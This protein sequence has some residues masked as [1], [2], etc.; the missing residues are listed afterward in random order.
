[1]RQGP[2]TVWGHISQLPDGVRIAQTDDRPSEFG[3]TDT[4]DFKKGKPRGQGPYIAG[5]WSF[6]DNTDGGAIDQIP[7]C[8]GSS[9]EIKIDVQFKKGMDD[10]RVFWGSDSTQRLSTALPLYVRCKSAPK[11]ANGITVNE[12]CAG[13]VA[14]MC[15]YA[16]D[17]SNPPFL[18][19]TFDWSDGTTD[20]VAR[21]PAELVCADH[22]WTAPG[23]YKVQVSVSAGSGPA[24]SKELGTIKA[25]DCRPPGL[26]FPQ[27]AAPLEVRGEQADI[28]FDAA[29]PASYAQRQYLGCFQF[30]GEKA[31]GP[32]QSAAQCSLQCQGKTFFAVSGMGDC[33]CGATFTRSAEG[34]DC[35][36]DGRR[37]GGDFKGGSNK[38]VY[39]RVGV[40]FDQ[41]RGDGG[42]RKDSPTVLDQ[43]PTKYDTLEEVRAKCLQMGCSSF[44]WNDKD[45]TVVTQK[46]VNYKQPPG[47]TCKTM[48]PFCVENP[49][50]SFPVEDTQTI[51]PR[52]NRYGNLLRQPVPNWF[53][54]QV[55]RSGLLSVTLQGR[56][57]VDFAVWGPFDSKETAL[58][59][60]GKLPWQNPNRPVQS[61]YSEEETEVIRFQAVSDSTYV[62]LVTNYAKVNQ[63]I[64]LTVNS[65]NTAMTDCRVFGQNTVKATNVA[66]FCGDDDWGSVDEDSKSGWQVGRPLPGAGRAWM[67]LTGDYKMSLASQDQA[68]GKLSPHTDGGGSF[69]FPELP[70]GRRI[71]GDYAMSPPAEVTVL[72]WVKRMARAGREWVL[73][74]GSGGSERAVILADG[75]YGGD[76]VAAPSGTAPYRSTVPSD[77]NTWM[78]IAVVY[79]GAEVTVLRDGGSMCGGWQDGPMQA[80]GVTEC[81]PTLTTGGLRQVVH[82]SANV[83]IGQLTVLPLA[84]TP[85]EVEDVYEKQKERYGHVN[86]MGSETCR[87]W[88]DLSKGESVGIKKLG[89]LPFPSLSS[90]YLDFSKKGTYLLYSRGGYSVYGRMYKC[91]VAAESSCMYNIVITTANNWRVEV[92][93]DEPAGSERGTLHIYNASCS[94]ADG[95]LHRAVARVS[96]KLL[97][98]PEA[99]HGVSDPLLNSDGTSSLAAGVRNCPQGAWHSIEGALILPVPL[100][101]NA[102]PGAYVYVCRDQNGTAIAR[103]EIVRAGFTRKEQ[104]RCEGQGGM[105]GGWRAAAACGGG[106]G[107]MKLCQADGKC[108]AVV[109]NPTGQCALYSKCTAKAA[110]AG[111]G[112]GWELWEKPE[113]SQGVRQVVSPSFDFVRLNRFTQDSARR[114]HFILDLPTRTRLRITQDRAWGAPFLSAAVTHFGEFGGVEGLCTHE[115]NDVPTECSTCNFG[116]PP[117]PVPQSQPCDD[118]RRLWSEGCCRRYQHCTTQERNQC[119]AEHC[120]LGD[121]SEGCLDSV[122]YA[123]SVS[124]CMPVPPKRNSPPYGNDV[125]CKVWGPSYVTPFAFFQKQPAQAPGTNETHTIYEISGGSDAGNNLAVHGSFYECGAGRY[126]MKQ[127]IITTPS[128]TNIEVRAGV[129]QEVSKFHVYNQDEAC[130]KAEGCVMSGQN[131]AVPSQYENLRLTEYGEPGKGRTEFTFEHS[132]GVVVTLAQEALSVG[133]YITH[134]G[135]LTKVTGLCT[136]DQINN[137][138]CKKNACPFDDS[139]DDPPAPAFGGTCDASLGTKCCTRYS[140]CAAGAQ[141]G[142]AEAH[143]GLASGKCIDWP[144]AALAAHSE[145]TATPA[146]P[147]PADATSTCLA[148]GAAHYIPFPRLGLPKFELSAAVDATL[149]SSGPY[150]VHIRQEQAATG[151]VVITRVLLRLPDSSDAGIGDRLVE[152]RADEPEGEER[153]KLRTLAPGASGANQATVLDTGDPDTN[154][155]ADLG[156]GATVLSYASRAVNARTRIQLRGGAELSVAWARTWRGPHLHVEIRHPGS[157]DGVEGLCTAEC[158]K[159]AGCAAELREAFACGLDTQCPFPSFGTPNPTPVFTPGGETCDSTPE[160]IAYAKEQVA[161]GSDLGYLTAAASD[162]PPDGAWEAWADVCCQVFRKCGTEWEQVCRAEHCA[163]GDPAEG[164]IAD[165][166]A[167][168][169]SAT[170]CDPLPPATVPPPSTDIK[171]CQAW[172]DPHINAFWNAGEKKSKRRNFN[173]VGDFNVYSSPG[174]GDWCT[175]G[176][177]WKDWAGEFPVQY[178]DGRTDMYTIAPSGLVLGASASNSG[179]GFTLEP[180]QSGVLAE[181][182]D[183]DPLKKQCPGTGKCAKLTGMF[184]SNRR[185]WNRNYRSVELLTYDAAQSTLKLSFLRQRR[186]KETDIT[187]TA[188]AT[189]KRARATP[190]CDAGAPCKFKDGEKN[191]GVGAPAVETLEDA[192]VEQCQ[193]ACCARDWCASFDHFRGPKWDGCDLRTLTR[194]SAPKVSSSVG[195]YPS[196]YYERTRDG[197]GQAITKY[198]LYVRTWNCWRGWVCNSHAL[199]VTPETRVE[200]RGETAADEKGRARVYNKTCPATGGCNVDLQTLP[201]GTSIGDLTFVN[202]EP[203]Q[204]LYHSASFRLP[205]RTTIT[206]GQ[207]RAWKAHPE[208]RMIDVA[209]QHWGALDGVTG[210]C[211]GDR[212]PT[213]G[214]DECPFTGGD[215]PKLPPPADCDKAR[216][217]KAESCC[218]AYKGCD[219]D[220]YDSCI[221]EHCALNDRDG[222]L[223][224]VVKA[225]SEQGQCPGTAPE[226]V[227]VAWGGRRLFPFPSSGTQPYVGNVQAGAALTLYGRQ[228]YY[229]HGRVASCTQQG[230]CFDAVRI[231]APD[232]SS[233]EVYR[234]AE[235]S[236]TWVGGEVD[237]GTAALPLDA[238]GLGLSSYSLRPKQSGFP[239]RAAELEFEL[240]SGSRVVVRQGS[241]RQLGVKIVHSGTWGDASGACVTAGGPCAKGSE[242]RDGCD[243]KPGPTPPENVPE[244]DDDKLLWADGCCKRWKDC[245][246]KDVKY[247]A[248]KDE[249]C[250]SGNSAEGCM[251]D[252]RWAIDATGTCSAGRECR[253]TG[254]D[255][256]LAVAA[257][258]SER[259]KRGACPLE[260]DDGLAAAARD[261]AMKCSADGTPQSELQGQGEAVHAAFS[262]T[263]TSLGVAAAAAAWASESRF[264]DAGDLSAAA[265]FAALMLSAARRVGCAQARVPSTWGFIAVVACRFDVAWTAGDAAAV[266]AAGTEVDMCACLKVTAC[267]AD[268]ECGLEGTCDKATGVCSTPYKADDTPCDDGD[269]TTWKDKCVSGICQG[270]DPCAGKI[271]QAVSQCHEPGECDPL[272]G[273]CSEPLKG[274]VP[275]DDG[276]DGTVDDKC[277][278]KGECVG[279]DVCGSAVCAPAGQCWEAKPC[280]VRTGQ[281]IASE[282]GPVTLWADACTEALCL[283]NSRFVNDKAWGVTFHAGAAEAATWP[284]DTV[285][286][287]VR[288]ELHPETGVVS[289]KG[290]TLLSGCRVAYCSVSPADCTTAELYLGTISATGCKTEKGGWEKDSVIAVLVPSDEPVAHCPQEPKPATEPC[291]DGNPSTVEDKC[292]GAGGCAGVDKCATVDCPPPSQCHAEGECVNTT[293][294]C[295]DVPLANNTECDDGNDRTVGDICVMGVCEGDDLCDG[296]DCSAP[297]DC[298][299]D[300]TCDPLTGQCVASPKPNGTACDDGDNTTSR[301]T[302]LYVSGSSSDVACTGIADPPEPPPDQCKMSKVCSRG[303][304]CQEPRNKPNN[305]ICDDGIDETIN[306]ACV[307]GKCVGKA[308]CNVGNPNITRPYLRVGNALPAEKRVDIR[309]TSVSPRVSYDWNDLGFGQFSDWL[310][311]FVPD[312]EG[313]ITVY[314]R[315]A[316]VRVSTPLFTAKCRLT[317]GPL[318]VTLIARGA[319]MREYWPP[320]GQSNI[321][322]VA[323]SYPPPP[324]GRAFVRL[325]NL[326]PDTEPGPNNNPPG[327]ALAWR[328]NGQRLLETPPPALQNLKNKLKYTVSSAW[329]VLPPRSGSFEV[330]NDKNEVMDTWEPNDNLTDAV[331]SLFVL[332]L[333]PQHRGNTTPQ[334]LAAQLQYLLDAPLVRPDNPYRGVCYAA[335]E[336]HYVGECNVTSGVCTKPIRPNGTD[337]NNGLGVCLGGQCKRVNRCANVTC[338]SPQPQCRRPGVCNPRTGQ[339]SAGELE[340]DGKACDDQNAKTTMDKC[341]KGWCV[342]VDLCRGVVCSYAGRTAMEKLCLL[343]SQCV[344]E[345]LAAAGTCPDKRRPEG[346]SCND[347][348]PRTIDDKC[349]TVGG[350]FQC[351]GTDRCQGHKGCTPID[352]CHLAGQC[353]PLSSRSDLCSI[354]IKDDNSPCDDQNDNTIADVCVS[355]V[356]KGTTCELKLLRDNGIKKCASGDKGLMSGGYGFTAAGDVWVDG[357]CG[358]V[359][360]VEQTGEESVCRSDFGEYT[361]CPLTL[362]KLPNCASAAPVPNMTWTIV[363]NGSCIDAAGATFSHVKV[364][365]GVQSAGECM[366]LAERFAGAVA[367]A[368]YAEGGAECRLLGTSGTVPSDR[369]AARCKGD[370][371]TQ[372]GLPCTGQ[373][374]RSTAA[375]PAG[376]VAVGCKAVG[377]AQGA[378][379]DA[380]RNCVV[381]G[382]GAGAVA[383]EATCLKSGNAQVTGKKVTMQ[384]WPPGHAQHQ[385]LVGAKYWAGLIRSKS[386][387]GIFPTGTSVRFAP[388]GMD[389]TVMDCT[390]GNLWQCL[391][392]TDGILSL[393]CQP[394]ASPPAAGAIVQAQMLQTADG[395]AKVSTQSS[396]KP[397]EWSPDYPQ[398]LE[399][400]CPA[401]QVATGCTCSARIACPECGCNGGASTSFAPRSIVYGTAA[402]VCSLRTRGARVQAICAACTEQDKV[403]GDCPG[404]GCDIAQKGAPPVVASDKK[405]SSTKCY[406]PPDRC[407][408]VE[409]AAPRSDCEDWGTC[410]P[411]TGRCVYPA[412]PAGSGCSGAGRWECD[413]NY[414]CVQKVP[415]ACYVGTKWQPSQECGLKQ[416]SCLALGS[417][418]WETLEECCRPGNAHP[419]GCRKAPPKPKPCWVPSKWWPNR[420]CT[421]RDTPC[422]WDAPWGAGAW[423]TKAG[424]C[425]QGCGHP[426]GCSDPPKTCYRPTSSA[427]GRRECVQDSVACGSGLAGKTY[428]SQ[429]E[430]CKAS[431]SDGCTLGCAAVDVVLL[432]D[433][434]GSMNNRFGNYA[435]GYLG[436]MDMVND[437]VQKLPLNGD[438]PSQSKKRLTASVQIAPP[439][440]DSDKL[441][442]DDRWKITFPTRTEALDWPVDEPF[443]VSIPVMSTMSYVVLHQGKGCSEFT[444][445]VSTSWW[446]GTVTKKTPNNEVKALGSADTVDACAEKAKKDSDCS[447]V[448]SYKTK[449]CKCVKKGFNCKPEATG[450]TTYTFAPQPYNVVQGKF[451]DEYGKENDQAD[452]QPSMD[453]CK[454]KCDSDAECIGCLMNCARPPGSNYAVIKNKCTEL[455]S[456]CGSYMHLKPAG[457]QHFAMQTQDTLSGCVKDA[458]CTAPDPADCSAAQWGGVISARDCNGAVPAGETSG[459]AQIDVVPTATP[460][461]VRVGMVQFSPRSGA[462]VSPAGTGTGGRIS[463]QVDQ[464]LADVRYH[465]D[466]YIKGWTHVLPGLNEA[467]DMFDEKKTVGSLYCDKKHDGRTNPCKPDRTDYCCDFACTYCGPAHYCKTMSPF[468]AD[469]GVCNPGYTG[470]VCKNYWQPCSQ[471]AAAAAGPKQ[472]AAVYSQCG[473][474]TWSG[475]TCCEGVCSCQGSD[476]FKQCM[477]P[478]NQLEQPN[479]GVYYPN[480][481]A[482]PFVNIVGLKCEDVLGLGCSCDDELEGAAVSIDGDGLDPAADSLTCEACGTVG[483]SSEYL[484]A[485]GTLYIKGKKPAQDPDAVQRPGFAPHR[486]RPRSGERGGA[487]PDEGRPA[488]AGPVRGVRGAGLRGGGAPRDPDL[489]HPQLAPGAGLRG[490][491]PRAAAPARP[492]RKRRPRVDRQ[493]AARLIHSRQGVCRVSC[494]LTPSA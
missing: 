93:A 420:E 151:V 403:W 207:N 81:A 2:A 297:D 472:C 138:P 402:T 490:G 261:A 72:V 48:A 338:E 335:S 1:M 317:P 220:A 326:M 290:D 371:S 308:R 64:T 31:K 421:L 129:P 480:V 205:T 288:A 438:D 389:C 222:C 107:G 202:W 69:V 179:G 320:T 83:R 251:D 167:D 381:T 264:W 113:D 90:V 38:C 428:D 32:V 273:E 372:R 131:V 231:V 362:G 277:D 412:K 237:A 396:A 330:Y 302:C 189:A 385:R 446:S 219:D 263:P 465:R 455:K 79:S 419:Q 354:P 460:G 250:A 454:A 168:A 240:P 464:L 21:A 209:V 236:L 483:L 159:G 339:C 161:K 109:V 299:N 252:V 212:L 418:I 27:C 184:R 423:E 169:V 123:L 85:D 312:T 35:D 157:M 78:H 391:F 29:C 479:D 201:P 253:A 63:D 322:C 286:S 353:D 204:K 166:V 457:V 329:S 45:V 239:R 68:D 210:L 74:C 111:T 406:T 260:W 366:R 158:D 443:S 28:D 19:Y 328:R 398:S 198:G 298:H 196:T 408:A 163:M 267:P 444:I 12:V 55:N 195:G 214:K 241:S 41:K 304:V 276:D 143:C 134:R 197:S 190:S 59:R 233:A 227:C 259:A 357:G 73:G 289:S 244:C 187:E 61:S 16:Y 94:G 291:D 397:G 5:R 270:E 84:L 203:G 133:V 136:G 218:S 101:G 306:D 245:D 36:C 411:T 355:G 91:G 368:E 481:Q 447:N 118:A 124:G 229:V 361:E 295:R 34:S 482:R 363:G 307:N 194:G 171:Y 382:F 456:G 191:A 336:C 425:A 458:D 56:F 319:H 95:C 415:K 47:P 24:A 178:S 175:K 265:R 301:S 440:K 215:D 333:H 192:T 394:P 44:A 66:W 321:V 7:L 182:K 373:G 130:L 393:D 121:P 414:T 387:R 88:G 491:H 26:P 272:N 323:A 469:S 75:R 8:N 352:Q 150:S 180:A 70:R 249:H 11:G 65:D 377:R 37:N 224:H 135:P 316:G 370:L 127:V 258:N 327:G 410:D 6:N 346:A 275:C 242:P 148:W 375:C 404:A 386:D 208:A 489:R 13:E 413:G 206:V 164:C 345:P 43:N 87:L 23:E 369:S 230:T 199:I 97:L 255:E 147:P 356:C 232:G 488:A 246:D 25:K 115:P 71:V 235:G 62:L 39:R 359:F 100:R 213:C 390:A 365:G 314:E 407:A 462:R 313:T 399:A 340:S 360:L 46:N 225:I 221:V 292:D 112:T 185:S 337:C 309:I 80:T 374:C 102:T 405:S 266:A 165:A 50:G 3:W 493:G 344:R 181:V 247:Q 104:M 435:R 243:W 376:R 409:C 401:G 468:R 60:C 325:Y 99:V 422:E 417:G 437:W 144:A 77:L 343:P 82:H 98:L 294:A 351:A 311:I 156:G 92:R 149:Y 4:L 52:G 348:D 427:G 430:C 432:L 96:N 120:S 256:T 492:A 188:T 193:L 281:P 132:S 416:G 347:G 58:S 103:S 439:G 30:S 177:A 108:R 463:G 248:C 278:P 228:G 452:W 17:S 451:C 431:F 200:I 486:R 358:G 137:Y 315:S 173:K 114:A 283:S 449:T 271:C 226:Q 487:Q 53:Y 300:G 155:P 76:F 128:L 116:D 476:W 22:A 172:G 257:I 160:R 142:C 216:M 86:G 139:F 433:G 284:P 459:A 395:G 473:G 282:S 122:R 174:V 49:L 274:N 42:C 10:W 485:T 211:V 54:M 303:G 279:I 183:S 392:N 280:E 478:A 349:T 494:S 474:K 217:A 450:F 453:K 238:G 154:L 331:A 20:E 152:F 434:S 153:G 384:V 350:K 466:N 162:T 262:S 388:G 186:R 383:A 477:P 9:W 436:M 378:E 441:V 67:D 470:G 367:G 445:T 429:D 400:T 269:D 296:V 461:G 125:R 254:V 57:D 117:K 223:A 40:E 126:C 293:G 105:I 176:T 170:G 334:A 341:A 287:A 324:P 33:H 380:Q 364:T 318:V 146:A 426:L 141:R 332:G 89:V 484:Q 145:C 471:G 379:L 448:W 475:P 305:T 285:F 14:T 110:C 268:G 424:C 442:G 51:A 467:V 234:N 310:N 119:V 140:G 342:G 15:A 106:E 18:N